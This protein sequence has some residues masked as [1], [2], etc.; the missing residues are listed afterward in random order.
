MEA[1][2][3]DGIAT[4]KL[5]G[6]V[7]DFQG[8]VVESVPGMIRVQLGNGGGSNGGSKALSWFGFRKKTEFVEME[9]HLDRSNPQQ[10]SLLAHHRHHACR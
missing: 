3:P 5:K 4:Y 9:L 7:H 6:F 8:E 1:W 2:M 10:Q